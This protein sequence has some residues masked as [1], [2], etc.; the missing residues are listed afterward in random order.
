[1]SNLAPTLSPLKLLYYNKTNIGFYNVK[2][3]LHCGRDTCLV[4][5]IRR[6]NLTRRI[7]D[8]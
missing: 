1:M 5:S 7:Q 2:T 6:R 3:A 4:K 8:A